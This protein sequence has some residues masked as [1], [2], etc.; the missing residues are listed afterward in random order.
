MFD[1][2]IRVIKSIREQKVPVLWL[3]TPCFLV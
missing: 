2:Y 1:V 3:K